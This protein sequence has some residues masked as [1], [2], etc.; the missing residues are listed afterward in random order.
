MSHHSAS[1]ITVRTRVGLVKDS[2]CFG[3]RCVR[4]PAPVA[5]VRRGGEGGHQLAIADHVESALYLTSL[6]TSSTG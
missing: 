3:N 1:R 6:M 2:C 4:L 5:S